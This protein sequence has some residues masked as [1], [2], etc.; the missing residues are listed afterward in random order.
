MVALL[1]ASSAFW[2][3]PRMVSPV[4]SMKPFCD[5]ET[6]RS[7]PHSSMRKSMAAIDETPSTQSSAGCWASSRALRTAATSLV[8]PVAVSLW[9]TKT[10]LISW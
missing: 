6:A 7:T 3:T 1:A 5:P 2:L 8:T 9:Q 4:G 10:A